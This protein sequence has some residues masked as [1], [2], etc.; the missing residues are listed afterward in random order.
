MNG[1][2]SNSFP[3]EVRENEWAIFEE[4]LEENNTEN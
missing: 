4:L 1:S 2:N 3:L